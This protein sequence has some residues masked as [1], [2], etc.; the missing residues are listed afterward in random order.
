MYA[1]HICMQRLR[2]TFIILMQRMKM[3]HQRKLEA[4]RELYGLSPTDEVPEDELKMK[5]KAPG[6]KWDW[7]WEYLGIESGEFLV[8]F[9]WPNG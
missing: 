4:A 2:F 9:W 3:V 5:A 6:I 1:C 7:D 8:N